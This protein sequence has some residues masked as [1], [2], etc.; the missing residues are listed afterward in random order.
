MR[1]YTISWLVIAFIFD[2]H[3]APLWHKHSLLITWTGQHPLRQPSS[4]CKGNLTHWNCWT[5]KLFW[6]NIVP[7]NTVLIFPY[8]LQKRNS[9][10]NSKF[11]NKAPWHCRQD[12]TLGIARHLYYNTMQIHI[13]RKTKLL[14]H[15]ARNKSE[16]MLPC[17]IIPLD[18]HT[19]IPNGKMWLTLWL[20]KK[21]LA[22]PKCTVFGSF[23]YMRQTVTFDYKPNAPYSVTHRTA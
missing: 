20:I 12:C 23:T 15:R 18:I 8:I 9:Y 19:H 11:G 21:N 10:P 16:L 6:W 22:T 1:L 13:W 4:Y 3:M 17:S 7:A 2:K 5:C 14:R